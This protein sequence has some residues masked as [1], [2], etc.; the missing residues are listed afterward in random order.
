MSEYTYRNCVIEDGDYDML[1][2]YR[3]WGDGEWSLCQVRYSGRVPGQWSNNMY[4][5]LSQFPDAVKHID[6]LG[7]A[8]MKQEDML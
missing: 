1:L 3:K 2:E 4:E 8:K 5:W 6:M 7:R